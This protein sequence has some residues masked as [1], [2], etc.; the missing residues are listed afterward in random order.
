MRLVHL[1][2]DNV[3][4]CFWWL[5]LALFLVF[6]MSWAYTYSKWRFN[7][8]SN[9]LHPTDNKPIIVTRLLDKI[10]REVIP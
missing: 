4:D 9:N 6:L 5:G 8:S 2:T 1:Y 10:I 7:A 3:D